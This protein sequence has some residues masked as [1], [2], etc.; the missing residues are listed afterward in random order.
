MENGKLH[1]QKRCLE[2]VCK[3]LRYNHM[4]SRLSSCSSS[5]ILKGI[6]DPINAQIPPPVLNLRSR[7]TKQKPLISKAASLIWS[8]NHVSVTN[9]QLTSLD[10]KMTSKSSNLGRSDLTFDNRKIVNSFCRFLKSVLLHS[11]VQL[12]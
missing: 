11:F 2:G 12:A 10:F 8:D 4:V 7:Q 3:G 5:R 6:L 9:A 1:I